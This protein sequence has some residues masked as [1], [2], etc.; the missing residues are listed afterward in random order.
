M[1]INDKI[2]L[3]HKPHIFLAADFETITTK[4][5]AFFQPYQYLTTNNTILYPINAFGF[6]DFNPEN[7]L[8]GQIELG[9][10]IDQM[11][12]IIENKWTNKSITCFFHNLYKFDGYVLVD[13][14]RNNFKLISKLDFNTK[15]EKN[16]LNEQY[17]YYNI[18][19]EEKNS[20]IL[21]IDTYLSKSKNK[22]RFQCSYR[23][24][25]VSIST[26]GK[27]LNYPKQT[28]DYNIEPQP[29]IN[30]YPKQYIDYLKTDIMILAKSLINFYQT[31]SKTITPWLMSIN[32]D[33]PPHPFQITAAS[34]SRKLIAFIDNKNEFHK[35]EFENNEI[36]KDYF[37]GGFT[38]FNY[39]Y[40]DKVVETNLKIYDAKSFYPTIMSLFSLPS[41]QM[42]VINDL[43]NF[44]SITD[45]FNYLNKLQNN[46][47]IKIRFNQQPKPLTK[48]ATIFDEKPTI[49][50]YTYNLEPTQQ[51]HWGGTVRELKA[52]LKF[53][54]LTTAPTIVELIHFKNRHSKLK[55]LIDFLYQL[56]EDPNQNALTFKILLNS[57]YGSLAINDNNG[58]IALLNENETN[59]I[60]NNTNKTHF[61][62]TYHKFKDKNEKERKIL[63]T[64]KF[65]HFKTSWNPF[66][67]KGYPSAKISEQK[68]NKKAKEY[69]DKKQ[70]TWWNKA[71]SA[72]ITST[73]RAILFELISI[74]P[75]SVFYCD[76]D[77]LILNENS[78][79]INHLNENNL[80]GKNLGQWEQE[81]KDKTI[82]KIHI[83]APKSYLIWDN[84]ELIKLGMKGVDKDTTINL[85]GENINFFENNTLI[86]LGAKCRVISLA[87]TNFDPTTFQLLAKK[88]YNQRYEQ[89][90]SF[91]PFIITKDKNLSKI[92]LIRKEHHNG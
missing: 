3:N 26:L 75:H 53:Y 76:T 84:N 77:S 2:F 38:S 34:L 82:N 66:L 44:K 10:N 45:F 16:E 78:K 24:L 72:Y 52:A 6:V 23:L 30:L 59:K 29:N 51:E 36:I 92:E 48:W 57:I 67:F 43:I 4:T 18:L 1:I 20:G 71:V 14:L 74:D 58:S 15:L 54:E 32:Q 80:I 65:E 69:Q 5:K 28:T 42:V 47:F 55:T 62:K 63:T 40:L 50:K 81:M 61:L 89:Q 56:K 68:W 7:G 49:E 39:N 70:K 12:N 25:S 22:V 83:L 88:S 91:Y 46:Q 41:N 37:R 90:N 33:Q 11:F 19:V 8:I 87:P 73:A 60:L 21:I 64:Y 85:I 27:N 86:P 9:T 17:N 13:W 31:F 79:I 35:I